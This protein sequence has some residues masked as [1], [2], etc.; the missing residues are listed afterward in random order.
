[1]IGETS[2]VPGIYFDLE[3]GQPDGQRGDLLPQQNA[4]Y[5]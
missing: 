1:M 4:I 2:V 3:F 5:L